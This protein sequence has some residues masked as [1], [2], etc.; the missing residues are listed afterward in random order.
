MSVNFIIS[1]LIISCLIGSIHIV[2]SAV[3]L[4]LILDVLTSLTGRGSS[5][6]TSAPTCASRS[7]Y[8]GGRETS[9]SNDT[10]GQQCDRVSLLF[11][12]LQLQLRY[13]TIEEKRFLGEASRFGLPGFDNLIFRSNFIASYDN[14]LKQP[15]WV[16]EHLKHERMT[17]VNAKKNP[18]YTFS[19][20]WSIHRYFRS[21]DHDYRYSDYDRR[22]LAPVCDNMAFQW[23]LDESFL[24]SNVAPQVPNLNQGGCI[25]TRLEGYV[26]YLA[27]RSKNIHIVTGTLQPPVVLHFKGGGISALSRR[28][29][30]SLELQNSPTADQW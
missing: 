26:L 5:P 28:N 3:R 2:C 18:R 19:P 15:V 16:L 7:M 13:R 14:R 11:A 25:W 20:D 27:R 21:R 17:L 23:M 6:L 29:S 9:L 12:E 8:P 4:G 10:A 30:T 22:H 24:F 1:M